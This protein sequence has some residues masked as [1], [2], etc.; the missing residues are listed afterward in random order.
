MYFLK[1]KYLYWI[2]MFDIIRYDIRVVFIN[3]W[4]QFFE[5]KISGTCSRIVPGCGLQYSWRLAGGAPFSPVRCLYTW[6]M[7]S[8]DLIYIVFN[9]NLLHLLVFKIPTRV[10]NIQTTIFTT[11]LFRISIRYVT[12]HLIYIF[13]FKYEKISKLISLSCSNVI[14]EV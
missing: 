3:L 7:K 9:I 5:H 6:L 13:R 4:C 10:K 11:I 1:E 8:D 12:K 14:E 2:K